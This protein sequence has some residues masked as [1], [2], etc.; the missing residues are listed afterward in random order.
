MQALV[1]M[2]YYLDEILDG[3]KTTDSRIH[4]TSVRGTVALGD[5]STMKVYGLADLVDCVEI[6]YDEFVRWHRTGPF[7]NVEFAPYQSGKPCYCYRFENVRRLTVPVRIPN[8]DGNRVWVPLSDDVVRSF[9][10]QRTL[11]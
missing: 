8:P 2:K 4:P 3:V 5:S 11:F 6:T 7:V 10:Y 9:S 1:M